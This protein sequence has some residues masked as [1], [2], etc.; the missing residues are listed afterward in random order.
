MPPS[1]FT[2]HNVCILTPYDL[3]FLFLSTYIY[4]IVYMVLHNVYIFTV[5]QYFQCSTEG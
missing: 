5:L 2:A 3:P 4:I 1:G